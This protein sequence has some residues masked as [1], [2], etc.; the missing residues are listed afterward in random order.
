M[1]IEKILVAGLAI[2][3]IIMFASFVKGGGNDIKA[4]NGVVVEELEIVQG[5]KL[6]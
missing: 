3:A 4:G 1:A 5:I 2:A 6:W